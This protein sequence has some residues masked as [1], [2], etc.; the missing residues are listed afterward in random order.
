VK[1]LVVHFTIQSRNC[2]FRRLNDKE[3]RNV[4]F[5]GFVISSKIKAASDSATKG[6]GD[7][8]HIVVRFHHL[9]QKLHCIVQTKVMLAITIVEP[10]RFISPPVVNFHTPF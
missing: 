2:A 4:S 7:G 3:M 10:N 9:Q 1:S 6:E 8:K 5:T